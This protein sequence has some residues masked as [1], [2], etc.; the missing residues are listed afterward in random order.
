M[1][2]PWSAQ[3]VTP[4][5][6][7]AL[8]KIARSGG[9]GSECRFLPDNIA[10]DGDTITEADRSHDILRNEPDRHYAWKP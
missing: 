10:L 3:L 7:L 4:V 8:K 2:E 5:P 9:L 6:I 1:G